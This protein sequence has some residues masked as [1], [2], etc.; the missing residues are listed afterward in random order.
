M[1]QILLEKYKL[2]NVLEY[3]K[4]T[5]FGG[6]GDKIDS[7]SEYLFKETTETN[8]QAIV[9]SN[10]FWDIKNTEVNFFFISRMLLKKIIRNLN[11]IF[12]LN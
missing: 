1:V 2:K 12:T 3:L 11:S 10:T 7:F 4:Q 5:L 9:N 8:W 6:F